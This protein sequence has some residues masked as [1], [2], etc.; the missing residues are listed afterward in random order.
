[1]WCSS[2]LDESQAAVSFVA[3]FAAV[4]ADVLEF[5]VPGSGLGCRA[6]LDW[7]WDDLR[8][9]FV[10]CACDGEQRVH[11]WLVDLLRG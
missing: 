8:D 4:V 9:D 6:R 10:D 5:P 7:R 1:M 2:V 3:D 11:R